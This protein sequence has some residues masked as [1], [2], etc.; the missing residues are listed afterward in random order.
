[1]PYT[2]SC[3]PLQT[4]V[5]DPIAQHTRPRQ[6]MLERADSTLHYHSTTFRRGNN[7]NAARARLSVGEP[8]TDSIPNAHFG[9]RFSHTNTQTH[10]SPSP[11]PPQRGKGKAPPP[12]PP[13]EE[14]TMEEGDDPNFVSDTNNLITIKQKGPNLF[15]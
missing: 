7:R 3:L 1:M 5:D 14:E 8:K 15:Q 4:C 13:I 11:P 6:N 2:G 9:P 12:P 10:L